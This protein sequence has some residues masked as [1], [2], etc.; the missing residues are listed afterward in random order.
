M[1]AFITGGTGFIG[2]HLIERLLVRNIEVFAL[3]RDPRNVKFLKGF[4][5][6]LLPGDLFSIPALPT[7]LDCV[8]HLAGL[9]KAL[10]SAD[11]YTVNQEGTASL[12]DALRRQRLSPK[13]VYLSSLAAAG[14]SAGGQARQEGDPPNP[15]TPYGESKLRGENEALA[16]RDCFSVAVLRVGGVFGPR[17][18]DFLNFF[19]FVQRGLLP[20]FGFKPRRLSVCYVKDLIRALD[21]AAGADLP[22]GEIFNIGDPVPYS[23]DEIG[24]AA[25]RVLGK[26]LRRIVVPLPIV[27]LAALG[28]GAAA[29]LARRPSIVNRQKFNE[30]KQE[31]WVADVRKA[32]ERLF[33]RTRYSLEDGLQ[34]TLLWYKSNGWL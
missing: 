32:K 20:S 26:T 7:D 23:F 18:R 29:K 15:V 13:I 31:G 1:K 34:E 11:Y 21:T 4:D 25:G 27:Y 33:F 8:F 5:I 17:D 6:H 24:R 22:S 10:K 9:T 16:R 2:S 3:V 30:L 14:P 28:S 12:F 19:K